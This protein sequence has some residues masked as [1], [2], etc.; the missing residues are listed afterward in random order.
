MASQSSAKLVSACSL[1]PSLFATIW[2]N[3]LRDGFRSVHRGLNSFEAWLV[4]A[5]LSLLISFETR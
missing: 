3:R 2:L 1:L 4:D 5:I